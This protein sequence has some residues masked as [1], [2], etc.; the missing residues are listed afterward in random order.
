MRLYDAVRPGL[1]DGRYRV[2]ARLEVSADHAPALP[3]TP[4]DARYVA[5]G[6]DRFVLP[7]DRIASVHPAAGAEGAFGQRL[8]HVALHRLTLP[9]ERT[10]VGRPWL[11]LLV[12]AEGDGRLERV[13]TARAAV[14]DQAFAA[15]NATEPVDGDG[16]PVTVLRMADPVTLMGLL[17]RAAE[18]DLLTHTRQVNLADTALAGADDDGWFAVVT[19]N[20]LPVSTGGYHACLVSL[21]GHDALV[22]GIAPPVVP[23]LVVL[24]SWAF[25]VSATG[26][27]FDALC[28]ELDVA[29]FAAAAA[30]LERVDRGGAAGWATYRSAFTAAAQDGGGD[31]PPDVTLDAAFELGR[32]LGAADGQ[33][34]REMVDWHRAADDADASTVSLRAIDS[35]LGA[36]NQDPPMRLVREAPVHGRR[37]LDSVPAV[38]DQVVRRTFRRGDVWGVPGSVGGVRR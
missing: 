17:P 8:P 16:P 12:V 27:L 15:L 11:A 5:V 2:R 38:L 33:F 29:S 31:A 19:A 24:H 18:L 6:S 37:P 28:A 36:L 21:E 4:E 3:A 13:P 26:G 30:V 35:A 32:L 22:A 25:T 20:R 7:D 1:V 9:W 14:G 34:T 10:V 23:P